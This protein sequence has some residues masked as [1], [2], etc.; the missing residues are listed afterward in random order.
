VPAYELSINQSITCWCLRDALVARVAE[1]DEE[2]LVFFEHV[3]VN[4]A[5]LNV[6]LGLSRLEDQC[7]S[8][9]HEVWS[10]V[11]RPVFSSVI[12]ICSRRSDV[13][14]LTTRRKQ[15]I[16]RRNLEP[17]DIYF[18][19]PAAAT[20]YVWSPSLCNRKRPLCKQVSK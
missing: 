8:R 3:V 2:M 12:H 14:T 10:G 17:A 9:E 18:L 15:S 16:K 7:S 13:A 20:D 6:T 19:Q 1:V 5:D 4:D 11:R